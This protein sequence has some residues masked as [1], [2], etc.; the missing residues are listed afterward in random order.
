M[1]LI[2]E[3]VAEDLAG[4][5]HDLQEEVKRYREALEKTQIAIQENLK[6]ADYKDEVILYESYKQNEEL[7]LEENKKLEKVL[8]FYANERNYDREYH[9]ESIIEIDCGHRANQLLEELK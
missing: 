3:S 9:G 2:D 6:R 8:R 7:L 4:T 5:I 1:R